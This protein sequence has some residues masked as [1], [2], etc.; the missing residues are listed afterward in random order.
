M[1]KWVYQPQ[2]LKANQIDWIS[3]TVYDDLAQGLKYMDS[4][5]TSL[6]DAHPDAILQQGIDA[7]QFFINFGNGDIHDY[8]LTELQVV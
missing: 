6:L 4:L 1:V 8:R 3:D 5:K 2:R 7:Q